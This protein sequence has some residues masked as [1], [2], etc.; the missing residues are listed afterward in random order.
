MSRVKWRLAQQ[1]AD[2]QR[3]SAAATLGQAKALQSSLKALLAWCALAALRAPAA[4]T[5]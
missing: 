3:A 4:L 1:Y 2:V 5:R